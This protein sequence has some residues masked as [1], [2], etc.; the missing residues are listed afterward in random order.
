MA[1][2]ARAKDGGGAAGMTVNDQP[3]DGLWIGKN[4]PGKT[5]AVPAARGR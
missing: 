5:T 1:G 3:A 4:F 2:A